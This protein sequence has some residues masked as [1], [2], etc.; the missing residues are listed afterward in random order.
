MATLKEISIN[1]EWHRY[2]DIVQALILGLATAKSLTRVSLGISRAVYSTRPFENDHIAIWNSLFALAQLNELE[3]VIKDFFIPMVKE[4][5]H[6]ICDVWKQSLQARRRIKSIQLVH[7][8]H[9]YW[10]NSEHFDFLSEIC[11]SYSTVEY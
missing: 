7:R 3:V 9:K 11:E 1:G 4:H 10:Y 5:A 2:P 8:K 6:L